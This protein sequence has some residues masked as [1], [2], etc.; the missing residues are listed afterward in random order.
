MFIGIGRCQSFSTYSFLHSPSSPLQV[1]GIGR[2][3]L[4]IPGAVTDMASP[5]WS[6][7]PPSPQRDRDG[8]I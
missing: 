4:N 5:R 8:A 2:E 1:V 7:M 6:S 3:A